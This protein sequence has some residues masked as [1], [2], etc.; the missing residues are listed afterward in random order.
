VRSGDEGSDMGAA[1]ST[2][3]REESGR[4][5]AVPRPE[6]RRGQRGMVEE[7]WACSAGA[8]PTSMAL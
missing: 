8:V 2:G 5:L 3:D 6:G 4:R 7:V 1:T